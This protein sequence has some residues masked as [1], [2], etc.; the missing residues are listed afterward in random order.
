MMNPGLHFVPSLR[1]VAPCRVSFAEVI[2]EM[3]PGH[4]LCSQLSLIEQTICPYRSN[5]INLNSFSTFRRI[6]ASASQEP[7]LAL[8]DKITNSNFAAKRSRRPP[9]SPKSK[10]AP[11]PMQRRRSRDPNVTDRLVVKSDDEDH[12]HTLPPRPPTSPLLLIR[13]YPLPTP[14]QQTMPTFHL[15][16]SKTMTRSCPDA[17]H[18]FLLLVLPLLQPVPSSIPNKRTR[19]YTSELRVL[20][21]TEPSFTV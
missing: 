15:S 10:F 17:S 5:E 21:S 4:E 8:Y 1:H 7:C 6:L 19:V 13:P 3:K 20:L 12:H 18:L 11:P 14:S 2:C 9:L 16:S